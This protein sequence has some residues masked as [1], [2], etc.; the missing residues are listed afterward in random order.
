MN[1]AIVAAA[2]GWLGTRFHH[3]GR[4]KKSATH[5]GGVDCL[6]LLVGI[7]ADLNLQDSN[8]NPLMLYDETSYPHNPDSKQLIKRLSEL[9]QSIPHEQMDS[10]DILLLDVQ[11]S[12]QHLAIVSSKDGTYHI[13]HAY[14]PAKAV[15]EHELDAWWQSRI[16]CVFRIA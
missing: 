11:G 3:Q 8:G 2:R 1:H 10:G 5:K 14:A 15:V 4:L 16:V 12:P 9:L 7:A 13:I 6:G